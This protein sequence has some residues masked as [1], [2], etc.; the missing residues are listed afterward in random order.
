MVFSQQ[1][2]KSVVGLG[3]VCDKVTPL[4]ALLPLSEP[5]VDLAILARQGAYRI[6]MLSDSDCVTATSVLYQQPTSPTALP[7]E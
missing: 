1:K 6:T 5:R 7:S 3:T 4:E 2:N